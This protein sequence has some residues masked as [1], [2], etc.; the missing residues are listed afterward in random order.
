MKKLSKLLITGAMLAGAIGMMMPIMMPTGAY[1]ADD[2]L[3]EEATEVETTSGKKTEDT[4]FASGVCSDQYI[5]DSLKIQAGCKVEEGALSNTAVNLINIVIAIIGL[6]AVVVVV[7]GG[8][9]YA[10]SL[11]DPGKITQAKNMIIYGVI[12]VV[13]AIMAWGIVQV[14]VASV[15]TL[16]ADSAATPDPNPDPDPDPEPED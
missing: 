14:V 10:V 13:V 5:D 9:Q 1:A 12:A 3:E 2:E 4:E 7:I 15:P 16:S 8:I 6:V 11:G